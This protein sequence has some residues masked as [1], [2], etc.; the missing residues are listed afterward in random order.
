M[1]A[2][3]LRRFLY[4]LPIAIGVTVVCFSL[5]HLAPGDPLN[6]VVGRMRR[7]MSSEQLKRAY[8]FDQPLPMQYAIWLCRALTAI[9]AARSRP[10]GRL[11][12]RWPRGRQYGR[13]RA[14]AAR[15]RLRAS[16]ACSAASPAT[17]AGAA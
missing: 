16:A 13:A 5:V 3:I 12:P 10:A 14:V 17:A 8:G 2:L 9:S 15:D 4:A 1:L 7:P 11:Q 6:A